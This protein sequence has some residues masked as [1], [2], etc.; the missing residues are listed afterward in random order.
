MWYL[1]RRRKWWPAQKMK[2]QVIDSKDDP[3]DFLLYFLLL[4]Q[5]QNQRQGNPGGVEDLSSHTIMFTH[6]QMMENIP[7]HIVSQSRFIEPPRTRQFRT[8]RT[9]P[10]AYRCS[11]DVHFRMPMKTEGGRRKKRKKAWR[12]GEERT[13]GGPPRLPKGC[14]SP[15]WDIVIT[16]QT[17]TLIQINSKNKWWL[18]YNLGLKIHIVVSLL[19]FQ[20][21][22]S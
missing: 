17:K 1:N 22:P 11:S 2:I 21:N 8:C 10:V 13:S 15:N 3:E 12:E 6:S 18:R 20:I 19:G 16:I 7:Q 4:K 5:N 9:I 14:P